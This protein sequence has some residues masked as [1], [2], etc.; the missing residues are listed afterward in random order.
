M[1]SGSKRNALFYELLG[2]ESN[3]SS[4][5]VTQAYHRAA[6]QHHPDKGGDTE[7]FQ[8]ILEAF[9]VLSNPDTRMQYD[10]E[11]LRQR[12]FLS[13]G[14]FPHRLLWPA[15]W[16][17]PESLPFGVAYQCE[18]PASIPLG[19]LASS[20][21]HLNNGKAEWKR[22]MQVPVNNFCQALSQ[23][24]NLSYC[25]CL[26]CPN[27]HEFEYVTAE[28]HWKTLWSIIEPEQ[29]TLTYERARRDRRF[30]QTFLLP[31]AGVRFNHLDGSVECFK[32]RDEPP[33]EKEAISA[34]S[35]IPPAPPPQ[36][37]APP[38]PPQH[39]PP[40]P[41]RPPPPQREPPP[42]PP[43]EGHA[44]IYQ[45]KDEPPIETET[46]FG[47]ETPSASASSDSVAGRT[48]CRDRDAAGIER[49]KA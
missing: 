3:A 38:P 23:S 34:V 24:G 15:S 21:P 6:L 48:P 30:W 44:P 5:E 10:A 39:E 31:N 33:I 7:A 16:P 26:M 40:P 9:D 43:P 41:P 20:L 45:S 13:S 46:G 17:E 11:L 32:G 28:K 36:R 27:G 22:Q 49:K 14:I 12:V 18:K 19:P 4:D 29:N 47:Q 1:E 2:L 25:P 35:N 8:N 37:E 42:P